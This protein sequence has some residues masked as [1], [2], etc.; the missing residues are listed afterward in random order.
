[1]PYSANSC[2]SSKSASPWFCLPVP[3]FFS[4]AIS[5]CA[6][7]PWHPGRQHSHHACQ[8]A[9]RSLQSQCNQAAFFEQ[10]I[11]QVRA[12]P[13]VESAGLVTKA[14]GQGWGGDS[15]ADIVERPAARRTSSTCICA[16]RI[17]DTLPPR[18]FHSCA[19][20]SSLPTSAWTRQRRGHIPQA[21]QQLFPR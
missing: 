16:L 4:R 10:L 18:K 7:G 13:G 8:P 19:A 12:L 9:R 6:D 3:A 17:P 11:T 5:A 14:P 21:A 2:L 15:L 1:M 20:A